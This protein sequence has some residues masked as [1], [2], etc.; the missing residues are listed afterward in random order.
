MAGLDLIVILLLAGVVGVN[1]LSYWLFTSLHDLVLSSEEGFVGERTA[2]I[3]AQYL[4]AGLMKGPFFN[5]PSMIVSGN[6]ETDKLIRSAKASDQYARIARIAE[7]VKLAPINIV[8][9]LI[10]R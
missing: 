1:A 4:Y 9:Y 2:A 10:L 7:Y 8:P 6:A 3:Y 5:V